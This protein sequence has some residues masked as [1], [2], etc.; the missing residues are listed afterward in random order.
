MQAKPSALLPQSE[1]TTGARLDL[2]LFT[3]K[4]GLAPLGQGAL[5]LSAN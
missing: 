4:F 5:V 1:R 3:A 2:E